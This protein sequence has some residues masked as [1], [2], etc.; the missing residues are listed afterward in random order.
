M[1][2]V[3]LYVSL[4]WQMSTTAAVCI[5]SKDLWKPLFLMYII[6]GWHM[7]VYDSNKRRLHVQR[8]DEQIK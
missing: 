2:A 7:H 1:M 5:E 6:C 8:H 4:S 3:A